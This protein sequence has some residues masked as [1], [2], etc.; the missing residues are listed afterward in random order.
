M[1]GFLEACIIDLEQPPAEK[2]LVRIVRA[3][4][5]SMFSALIAK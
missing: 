2:I 5:I 1:A 4:I 3:I